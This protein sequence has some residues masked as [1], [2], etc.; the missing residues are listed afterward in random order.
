MT[1]KKQSSIRVVEEYSER[2]RYNHEED[3][4]LEQGAQDAKHV[5]IPA[6][7]IAQSEEDAKIDIEKHFTTSRVMNRSTCYGSRGGVDFQPRN[8]A[9]C[10]RP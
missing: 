6:L 5:S 1:C 4:D 7:G 8:L 2:L 3:D 9:P 10:G